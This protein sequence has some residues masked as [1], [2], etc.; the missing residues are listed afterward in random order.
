MEMPNT[1]FQLD[2][3]AH[4]AR[5]SEGAFLTLLDGRI[6]YAWSKFISQSSHDNE[7]SLIAA[8]ISS[9]GGRTW[10]DEELILAKPERGAH[11][12]MSVSLLRLH[13]GRICLAYASKTH[14][15][16]GDVRCIPC[17][18]FSDDEGETWT[19]E[20]EV[21]VSSDYHVVNNDRLIQLKDGTLVIP[22]AL[23][24]RR[25]ASRGEANG[26]LQFSHAA[27]IFFFIS[28][29]GGETWLESDNSFYRCFPGGGGLQEP[30]V[31]EL[32][33]GRLWAWARN[34][35]QE[36]DAGRR[37]WQSISEDGG[38]LWSE[39]EPSY[40]V[41]PCSPLS[42]KRIPSTGDLLAV[43]NDHSGRFPL[44][45]EPYERRPLACAISSDEGATWKLHQLLDDAPGHGYHYTAIHFTDDAVLLAYCAGGP[46]PEMGWLQRLR[47]QRIPLTELY[48]AQSPEK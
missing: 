8:R 26:K 16:T 21:T 15:P 23:H 6:L 7:P 1:V 18:R 10:A 35:W 30:G 43:W 24:R 45:P 42:I 40:F 28:R 32:S 33:D 25:L 27:L 14:L 46:R 12:L 5:N 48:A 29:D 9:D 41:S 47:I 11:N 44:P 31:I 4:N 20:K 34:S 36:G 38:R 37:Q 19:D 22:V 13:S 3:T 2:P 17:V 39:P